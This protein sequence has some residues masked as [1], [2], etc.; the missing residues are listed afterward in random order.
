M[1]NF[2]YK[3]QRFMWGRNGLDGLGIALL[4]I[5]FI[6]RTFLGFSRS[7]TVYYLGTLLSFLVLAFAIYRFLSKNL[8]ARHREN[9]FFMKYFKKVSSYFKNAKTLAEDRARVRDTHK[10]YLCPKCKRKLKVPKGRGKIE[11]SCPCSYKFYK[12]T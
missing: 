6:M 12:R 4:I 3:I 8:S 11:I 2:L 7:Y 10:I 5:Y 1:Q 9:N